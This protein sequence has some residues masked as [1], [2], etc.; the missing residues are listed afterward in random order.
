MSLIYLAIALGLL[1]VNLFALTVVG[2]RLAPA[3]IA[4]V[5]GL[6]AICLPLFAFE[7]FMG[8]GSLVW[9]W[10]LTTSASLY[11][12]WRFAPAVRELWR[13]EMIFLM[14]LGYG[15]L[16]RLV[17]SNIDPAGEALT[18]LYFISNYLS[19][20]TLPPPDRW[21]GGEQPFDF[22]YGFQHYVA[23]LMG[24]VFALSPGLTLN[25]AGPLAIGLMGS[26]AWFVAA[27]WIRPWWGRVLVV[28]TLL[29]GG[30]GLTPLM[31]GAIERSTET[32]E[33]RATAAVEQ[34]WASTRF[35]GLY[36][37][38]VNTAWGQRW[39]LEPMQRE[40]DR[41]AMDLPL[42]TPAYLLLLGDFH[43]PLGGWV[44]LLFALALI[45]WIE[46]AARQASGARAP[47]WAT[48]VLA[49]TPVITLVTN[50]WVFP[51]Q[52][53]LVGLWCAA[54][55]RHRELDWRA[56]LAGVALSLALVYPF[57]GHFAAHALAPSIEPV[58]LVMH[59][60]WAV[61]LGLHW[62]ALV[63]LVLGFV[64]LVIA[65]PST[66]RDLWLP[67]I[68]IV[69]MLGFSEWLFFDDP[70][71][72]TFE[73][74]NTVLKSWSWL[75]PLAL[76]A[77]VPP[78]WALGGRL[79]KAVVAT[80]CIALLANTWNIGRYLWNVEIAGGSDL[81]GAGWLRADMA[82]R[83]MLQYL[84]A[85][86][87]G[88]V[89]ERPQ[90]GAYDA[91]SAFAL[92]AGKPAALGW[93]QHQEGWV[94]GSQYIANEAMTVRRFFAGELP[95]ANDW[96]ATRQVRYVVWSRRDEL[97]LPGMRARLDELIGSR[98]AF[99]SVEAR[100]EQRI[101]YWERRP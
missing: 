34:L 14:C 30:N 25:L 90:G 61:W 4:R 11:A 22:Y 35:S 75:W 82:Q 101:G 94:G 50:A 88:V 1:L 42:E 69:T 58:P 78:L 100:G 76:V 23:A 87:P 74:F 5:T 60:R 6:L 54:R 19:G 72:G 92:F 66:P 17:D 91:V 24:R 10:P 29:L 33:A 56:A 81:S 53:L 49:A 59:T 32:S 38:R 47:P 16:W 20:E 85:A 83:E 26:L 98:Y 46:G 70:N 68:V 93:P 43:P 86:P 55:A 52:A 8:L 79:G 41:L 62:P 7:H 18:D 51:W 48:G 36:E 89:L 65:R 44:L 28:A 3:P 64:T 40:T 57:L 73:R 31:L 84:S 12:L 37:D 45:A 71:G 67:M 63:L 99:R 15:L 39:L 21:L 2:A 13:A 9:V 27:R 97:A 77:L 80:V 95:N 96:L